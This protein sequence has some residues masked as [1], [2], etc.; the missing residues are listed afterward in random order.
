MNYGIEYSEL[1]VIHVNVKQD[2]IC[3]RFP[4]GH[5]NKPTETHAPLIISF[6]K[7]AH[8]GAVEFHS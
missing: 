3:K 2:Q 8:L 4:E 7:H 1:L 6:I 5:E